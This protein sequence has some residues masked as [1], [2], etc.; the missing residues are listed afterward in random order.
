VFPLLLQRPARTAAAVRVRHA[1][2]A[3]L[4]AAGL[5]RAESERV[6]RLMSTA[7]L[8][9]AASEAAG[10]F[11]DHAPAVLDADFASLLDMLGGAIRQRAR[12][13]SPRAK[14]PLSR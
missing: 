3:A 10:R 4:E 5:G 14:R 12:H 7:I 11:A 6:E 2:R 13:A 9:F 1:A 8:G